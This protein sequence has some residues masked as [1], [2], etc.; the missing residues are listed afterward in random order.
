M[1]VSGKKGKLCKLAWKLMR[2]FPQRKKAFSSGFR[3]GYSG[4]QSNADLTSC[5]SGSLITELPSP[6]AVRLCSLITQK[7]VCANKYRDWKY[8]IFFWP[9]WFIILK[10]YAFILRI[11]FNDAWFNFPENRTIHIK[12]Q[13]KSNMLKISQSDI[14]AFFLFLLL[15]SKKLDFLFE[16]QYNLTKS[17]HL[18]RYHFENHHKSFFFLTTIVFLH[19][20]N[21]CEKYVC[22]SHN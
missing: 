14:F 7:I 13:K 8:C 16:I 20:P 19:Y 10:S 22:K 9:I 18:L 6:L 2:I 3:M 15:L 17:T 12:M 5:L 11:R 4:L 1:T 21:S